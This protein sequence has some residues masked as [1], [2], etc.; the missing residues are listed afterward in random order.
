MHAVDVGLVFHN[1]HQPIVGN[2]PEGR[3]LADQMAAMWVAF[4]K[5]G[6]PNTKAFPHWPAYTVD[7]RETLV[8]N[9]HS[10]VVNDPGHD[11]RLLWDELGV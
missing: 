8:I 1:P 2:G 11:L 3:V 6:D 4:A 7:R 10:R 5:V 9:T